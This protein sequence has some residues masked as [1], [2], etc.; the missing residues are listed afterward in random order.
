MLLISPIIRLCLNQHPMDDAA[1]VTYI[2]H[3]VQLQK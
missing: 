2:P 3:V 1:N